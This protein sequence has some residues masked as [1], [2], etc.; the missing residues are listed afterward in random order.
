MFV[1]NKVPQIAEQTNANAREFYQIGYF[2]LSG[3][4]SINLSEG[5]SFIPKITF[6]SFLQILCAKSLSN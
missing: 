1:W 3:L 4:L 2:A 5:S 6:M